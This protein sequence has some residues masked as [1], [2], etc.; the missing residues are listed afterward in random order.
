MRISVY[1]SLMIISATILS[2]GQARV[3]VG[4]CPTSLY[5]RIPQPFGTG[6]SVADGRY[7]MMR[8][9]KQFKWGWETFEAKPG[10]SFDCQYAD[11]TKTS[12]GFT[13]TQDKPL[14][15]FRYWP[16]NIACD[17]T[18]GLCDSY[19]PGKSTEVIYHDSTENVVIGYTCFDLMYAADFFMQQIKV[20]EFFRQLFAFTSQWLNQLHY[21]MMVVGAK[22]PTT[23]SAGALNAVENFIKNF[24]DTPSDYK[25]DIILE[26]T[27]FLFGWD[28]NYK[29]SPSF[30]V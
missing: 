2:V 21:S 30:V 3:S 10:E 16:H 24:P 26:T 29:Y 4:G 15:A 12:K 22:N 14:A 27:A 7:H 20:P 23:V 13:W 28:F 1:Q 17:S 25:K 9:D 8:F 19:F 11:V 6:G 18:T 5:N